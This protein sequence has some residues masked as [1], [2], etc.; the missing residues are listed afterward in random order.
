[1][2]KFCSAVSVS[3]PASLAV[4]L[5]AAVAACWSFSSN[6]DEVVPPGQEGSPESPVASDTAGTSGTSEVAVTPEGPVGPAGTGGTSGRPEAVAMP[7]LPLDPA[8]TGGTSSGSEAVAMP[9]LPIDPAG[10]GGG[11]SGSAGAAGE[12][13]IVVSTPCDVLSAGGNPCVAAHSTVRVVYGGYTGPLYQVCRGGSVPGPNSCRGG[14]TQDIGSVAGGYA[15]AAAQDAFCA[16]SACT[17]SIIYDQSPSGN[18]LKPAPPGGAKPTPDNPANAAD[19]KTTINGH[20]VYGVFIRVGMGYRSGCSACEAREAVGTAVDDE[21]ETQ[22][23]VTSAN[24]LVNGCCFDYGNAETTSRDDGN[25]TMEALYFGGGVVWGTGS[26]GG[27]NNGPWVMADLENGLYA[28]W[29][30]NQDQN[31]STNTPIRAPFVMGV[32]VGDTADKNGGRGR[33]AIYGG[34][35]TFGTLKTLYDGT[36]PAKPGYV[37]MQKQGSIILGIG[38]DNSGSSAGQF[39]EGVMTTGAATLATVNALQA[40]IVAAGYGK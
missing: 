7:E 14:V 6:P 17:I 26:P 1:M 8:G 32:L 4:S 34:D 11:M 20:S 23:M 16:G 18:D 28:G 19:L 29:Q 21:P 3:L 22:Y 10:T 5:C 33:F 27:H 2:K 37:P 38:G 24:G 15:D 9:E 13:P 40:N 31:I 12:A 30:N 25:G 39:F 35:A 36:R